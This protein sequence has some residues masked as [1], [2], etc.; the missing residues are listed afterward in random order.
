MT[1]PAVLDEPRAFGSDDQIHAEP[2][3]LE[4]ALGSKLVQ[5]SER[6]GRL[7]E[8]GEYVEES[9]DGDW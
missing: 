2:A 6:R 5:L 3:L 4:A 8:K 9:T 7:T 1:N